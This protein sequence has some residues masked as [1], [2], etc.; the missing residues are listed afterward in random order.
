MCLH[1]TYT[2]AVYPILCAQPVAAASI[3]QREKLQQLSSCKAR[4]EVCAT[5]WVS[6]YRASKV[7]G[8]WG[9]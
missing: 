2:S 1:L 6:E 9:V 8:N 3:P 5:E 7:P 4:Q